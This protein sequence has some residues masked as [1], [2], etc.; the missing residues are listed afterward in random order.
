[1]SEPDLLDIIRSLVHL[2]EDEREALIDHHIVGRTYVDIGHDLG[3][4]G[5]RARQIANQAAAKIAE[6]LG[7]FERELV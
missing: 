7:P 3:V 6:K 2:T 1:M 4:S 5:E